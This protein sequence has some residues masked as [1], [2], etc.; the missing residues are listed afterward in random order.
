M[1]CTLLVTAAP[2]FAQELSCDEPQKPM[3]E[4]DLMFGR[5]SEANSA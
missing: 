5:K 4:I 1:A 3:L 2:S